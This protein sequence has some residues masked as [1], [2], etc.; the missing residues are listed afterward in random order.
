MPHVQSLGCSIHYEVHGPGRPVLMLHGI[1]VSFEANFVGGGWTRALQDAGLQVI[2]L[3]LRGHGHSDKPHEA[4]AYGVT[5]LVDDAIAVLDALQL[6]RASLVGYSLGSLIALHLLLRHPGRFDRA[7][8]VATGDGM[9]GRPPLQPETVFAELAG[10]L[11]HPQFPSHL[12]PHVAAYWDF[13]ERVGGDRA[14]AAACARSALP[15]LSVLEASRIAAPVLVVSGE[16]DPVL[17]R[18]PALAAAL[19]RGR[20]LEVAGADHFQLAR[21]GGAQAAVA[22]FLAA[23]AM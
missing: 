11:E 1:T 9:I 15:A 3:D 19:P 5:T 14:A 22:A 2:G 12:P 23:D 6:E 10:A 8:L 4:A 16:T 17:G 13:A 20:Y 18:G 7:A 21:H